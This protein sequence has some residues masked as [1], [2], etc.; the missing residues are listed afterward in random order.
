MQTTIQEISLIHY[1]ASKYREEMFK[2]IVDRKYKSKPHG[3]LWA[4][5]I[6][7]SYG[8]IDWCNENNYGEIKNSFKF[9]FKGAVL[10]IRDQLAVN[11]LP[12]IENDI[13]RWGLSFE[14]IINVCECDAVHL[15]LKALRYCEVSD[16]S[17]TF[18]GWDCET[19]LILNPKSII[20]A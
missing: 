10:K 11:E 3:G 19:V 20:I 1:G 7:S 9:A 4:S 12:W 8:W 5:P 15:S 13:G 16:G 18:D 14:E 2:P 17:R 6:R